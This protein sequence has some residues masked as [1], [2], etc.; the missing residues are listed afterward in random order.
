MSGDVSIVVRMTS[1]S[2]RSKRRIREKKRLSAHARAR[3]RLPRQKRATTNL[4]SGFSTTTS[5]DVR[6]RASHPQVHVRA[7]I[8]V[9]GSM[10]TRWVYPHHMH[11]AAET[12]SPKGRG[13]LARAQPQLCG[14]GVANA[15]GPRSTTG[16][17]ERLAT[18]SIEGP[19]PGRSCPR[20]RSA[21]PSTP[22]A[23]ASARGCGRRRHPCTAAWSWAGLRPGRPP[24]ANRRLV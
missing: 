1:L 19:V 9:Q 7:T 10:P 4:S 8:Q 5:K 18:R 12:M 17:C 23:K 11:T 24:A 3:K 22:C 15:P 13:S 2:R 16:T 20:R 6:A 21:R 14:G